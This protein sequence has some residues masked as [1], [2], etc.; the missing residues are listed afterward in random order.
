M[1]DQETPQQRYV[2][3][4]GKTYPKPGTIDHKPMKRGR[5]G[6]L[7]SKK[8]CVECPLARAS[9]PGRLGGYTVDQ[10]LYILHSPG[11]I[12]CHL[13]PGFPHTL[14]TQRSCTGVAMYRANN[15]ITAW[16]HAEEST[17]AIGPDTE[18]S[19]TS[20]DEFRAHHEPKD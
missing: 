14:Q 4:H 19:F 6:E 2:R 20:P 10:F 13:S 18:L 9:V 16:G 8:P 3:E 17:Q 15:G 1:S 7:P 11:D 12:A 5:M